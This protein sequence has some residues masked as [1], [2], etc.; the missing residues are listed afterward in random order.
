MQSDSHLVSQLNLYVHEPLRQRIV[1]HHEFTGLRPDEVEGF[2]TT[3]LSNC[4]AT[5]PLFTPDAI[6]AIAGAS[7]GCPR[8]ICSLAEK[9]LMIGAQEKLQNIAA[10]TI[11]AAYEATM[12]FTS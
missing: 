10:D 6:E 12:I 1:V 9:A 7:Q 5:Q 2:I 8:I 3:L 11:Q 4:G